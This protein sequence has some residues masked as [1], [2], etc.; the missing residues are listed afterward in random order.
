M[1]V[2]VTGGAGYIGS[3]IVH[4]LADA[5]HRPIVLDSLRTGR[6][7]LIG[8]HPFYEGDVSD[9]GVLGEIIR[10]HRPDAVVHCAA[11]IVVPD[12]ERDPGLY[13]QENV[14]RSLSLFTQLVDAGITRVLFSSSASVYGTSDTFEVRE[15][16]PPA[17]QS[18]YARTKLVMEFILEDISRAT[19]MQAIAL[20]YFNPIGADAQMRTGM[21]IPKPTHVLGQML[22]AALGRIPKFT[23]TGTEY[24]TRDGSGLR[25]YIHVSDLAQAHVAALEKFDSVFAG[26]QD[27]GTEGAAGSGSYRVINIGTGTGVTV[28]E[29]LQSCKE[30][31]GVDFP[32]VEAPPRPG[33]VAGCYASCELARRLLG[34]SGERSV[35]QAITDHFQWLKKRA[36]IFG[37]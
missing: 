3:H 15:D 21:I 26:A 4:E 9:P 22:D 1:R 18:P 10:E 32:V 29:L 17:P 31:V 24:D 33:D 36:D 2:L 11:L 30:V 27:T 12:S 8:D 14:V 7:E 16:T 34:W 23:I 5:G 25:D 13:Y 19:D 6:R 35:S 28:R 37:Y 20:R